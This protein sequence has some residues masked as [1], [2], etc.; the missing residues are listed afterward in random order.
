MVKIGVHLRELSQ[1]YNRG[2]TFW[3]TLY[4]LD[5]IHIVII[6]SYSVCVPKI[7]KLIGTSYW[8]NNQGYFF[9]PILY[10]AYIVTDIT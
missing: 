1:N 3:T 9:W 5:P 8:N 2:I 4:T 6:I 10:I 7:I